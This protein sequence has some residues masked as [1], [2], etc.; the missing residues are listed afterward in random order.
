LQNLSAAAR[1]SSSNNEA[2][3]MLSAPSVE[4]I[5]PPKMK[6]SQSDAK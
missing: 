2:V 5:G 6:L 3:P 4:R 1:S